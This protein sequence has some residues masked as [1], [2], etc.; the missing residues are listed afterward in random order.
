M[1][2]QA[3]GSL[4]S[5]PLREKR[6]A[7]VLNPHTVHRIPASTPAAYHG[8]KLALAPP[9]SDDRPNGAG[10]PRL[11]SECLIPKGGLNLTNVR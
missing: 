10:H 5:T 4:E 7:H 9:D 11:A 1:I 3:L 6:A 2:A 8:Q